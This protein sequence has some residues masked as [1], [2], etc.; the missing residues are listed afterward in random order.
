[1]TSGPTPT[2][3]R[4]AKN[5]FC[6]SNPDDV[7][8][9][10]IT[11]R[12]LS[13]EQIYTVDIPLGTH[14]EKKLLSSVVQTAMIPLEEMRERFNISK[15]RALQSHLGVSADAIQHKIVGQLFPEKYDRCRGVVDFFGSVSETYY[16]L[17]D[18]F[19]CRVFL[20]PT[21]DHSVLGYY[22]DD[23]EPG[24]LRRQGDVRIVLLHSLP[25][26][27]EFFEI[28]L[29][30]E[31]REEEI[32]GREDENMLIR[33]VNGW[34]DHSSI[35]NF[36]EKGEWLGA[37]GSSR[38]PAW[39][40]GWEPARELHTRYPGVDIFRR[41]SIYE[42]ESSEV[43]DA[44]FDQITRVEAY[45]RDIAKPPT[46]E[47]PD[48]L[49]HRPFLFAPISK[50]KFVLD[51]GADSQEVLPSTRF[52]DVLDTLCSAEYRK[53]HGIGEDGAGDSA[54][55]EAVGDADVEPV[56]HCHLYAIVQPDFDPLKDYV[57]GTERR[58]VEG[59][60]I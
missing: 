6:F 29:R 9:L 35:C 49:A 31:P 60:V 18:A 30:F 58:I 38:P 53:E 19:N 52:V 28:G 25:E 34:T 24:H 36:L 41:G 33:V 23:H 45:L 17:S 54:G 15:V 21:F 40:S 1:M 32:D 8:L 27:G 42:F 5:R 7:E 13:G 44:V 43:R 14:G 10:R 26:V 39:E 16:A 55:E 4:P 50:L 46:D 59:G 3:P 37:G 12:N 56:L 22:P 11:V 57:R 48:E 2:S 51:T 20:S 47:N